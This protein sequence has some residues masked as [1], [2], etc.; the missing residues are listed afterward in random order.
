MHGSDWKSVILK[1][2][3]LSQQIVSHANK[4]VANKINP[5]T[6]ASVCA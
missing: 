1:L 3:N 2:F 6:K 5:L 4:K